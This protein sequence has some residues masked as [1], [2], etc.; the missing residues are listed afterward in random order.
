MD[1]YPSVEGKSYIAIYGVGNFLDT[2]LHQ[3]ILFPTTANKTE[4]KLPC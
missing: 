2:P 1:P 4:L 3:F